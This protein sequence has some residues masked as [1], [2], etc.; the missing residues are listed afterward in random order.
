MLQPPVA[1]AGR[2]KQEHVAVEV[3]RGAEQRHVLFA[4]RLQVV[5]QAPHVHA[6][7]PPDGDRV[8]DAV[9][10]EL[11]DGEVTSLDR[12]VPASGRRVITLTTPATASSGVASMSQRA[13]RPQNHHQAEQARRGRQNPP[14]PLLQKT[15][16]AR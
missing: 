7:F 9:Y 12:V 15:G 6:R 14:D 8:R 11:T 2:M 3:I 16:K 4:E 1:V 13:S 10:L 5:T